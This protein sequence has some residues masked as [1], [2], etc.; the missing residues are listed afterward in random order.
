[1]G[2]PQKAATAPSTTRT[3]SVAVLGEPSGS[4][5]EV[6]KTEAVEWSYRPSSLRIRS[7]QGRYSTVS[8]PSVRVWATPV[9]NPSESR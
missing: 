2:F 4:T 3:W 8:V 9:M 6:L 7:S 5:V 1:M